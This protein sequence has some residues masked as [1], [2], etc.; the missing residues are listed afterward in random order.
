MND[1]PEPGD[2]G[3]AKTARRSCVA[4]G[5]PREFTSDQPNQ[6]ADQWFVSGPGLRHSIWTISARPVLLH[7]LDRLPTQRSAMP[8]TCRTSMPRAAWPPRRSPSDKVVHRLAGY[9]IHATASYRSSSA[10]EARADWS[11]AGAFAASGSTPTA[12][13]VVG[14]ASVITSVEKAVTTPARPAP[15][16]RPALQA[17]PGICRGQG[18][19]LDTDPERLQRHTSWRVHQGRSSARQPGRHRQ[20]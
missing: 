14:A 7:G 10:R 9:A 6:T 19:Y 8:G 20:V 4:T 3:P 1:G 5:T 11:R 18:M 13:D 15:R 2:C 12:R 16:R 17:E